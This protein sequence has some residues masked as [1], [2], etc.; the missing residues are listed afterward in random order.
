M[1]N[2][3]LSLIPRNTEQP[4]AT[5]A[6][7][8]LSRQ[9]QSGRPQIKR[10]R[11]RYSA[12][13]D[14]KLSNLDPN[15]IETLTFP[16]NAV[17]FTTQQRKM[18][19]QQL[20]MHVQLSTQSFLQV[21]AHPNYF[22]RQQI[23]RNFLVSFQKKRRKEPLRIQNWNRCFSFLQN[24]L[25]DIVNSSQSGQLNITNL[26]WALS[27]IAEW[28]AELSID[29]KEN[30]EIIKFIENEIE[31]FQAA[32]NKKNFYKMAFPKRLIQKICH[33]K[34]FMYPSLL[35]AIPFS[36]DDF[37]TYRFILSED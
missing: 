31:K 35:P 10:K 34:V 18:L 19:D 26:K 5:D 36:E 13:A 33:S 7:T 1:G 9:I 16:E 17:G 6:M 37:K 23:F 29:T 24:E 30:T 14:S 25:N 3:D 2:T 8:C 4:K 27:L 22:N 21:Y 28:E 15:S 12:I 20:R 11:H 32:R